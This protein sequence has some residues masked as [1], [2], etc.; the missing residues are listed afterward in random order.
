MQANTAGMAMTTTQKETYCILVEGHLDERFSAWLND[1]AI[2]H[3]AD[4][5]T[6]L[7]GPVIDQAALYGLLS[8]LRDLGLVLLSVTSCDGTRQGTGSRAKTRRCG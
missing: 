3:D 4:G 6:T 5:T 7:H 8:K 1:L 2:V